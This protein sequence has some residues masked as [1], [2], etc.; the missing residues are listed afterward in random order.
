MLATIHRDF[1]EDSLLNSKQQKVAM[2]K[3]FFHFFLLGL[4]KFRSAMNLIL[5]GCHISLAK[6]S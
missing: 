5:P 1:Q 4:I 3:K 6:I 2:Y